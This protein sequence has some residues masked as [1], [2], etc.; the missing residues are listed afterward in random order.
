MPASIPQPPTPVRSDP[1]YAPERIWQAR[2]RFFEHGLQPTGYVDAS[3]I[4]SWERCLQSGFSARESIAFESVKRSDLQHLLDAEQHWLPTARAELERLANG[5]RQAGYAAMLTDA[6]GS[7][8][9]VAGQLEQ[10][11]D[12]FRWAFRP[13]VD[14]SE[15]AIGT[16]AMGLAIAD[17]KPVRVLGGEHF[18][19][20]NQIFH[21]FAAP[22]FDHQGSLLGTIDIS[23]DKPGLPGGLM[24]LAQD[25]AHRIEA[26]LFAALPAYLRVQLEGLQEARLAFNREGQLIA[27]SRSARA[28]VSLTSHTSHT[29]VC[30]FEDIF[31]DRFD[32]WARQLRRSTSSEF[33]LCLRNGIQLRG[34]RLGDLPPPRTLPTAAPAS[35]QSPWQLPSDAAF[36]AE[37]EKAVRAFKAHIPILIRGETGAGKELA[38]RTIHHLGTEN[39][40]PFVAINCGNFAPELI[41]SEL[42]GH[43]D[44]AFTGAAR[45]GHIGKIEAANGGTVLLDEVGDMPLPVQV[46]LLRVLDNGEVIPVGGVQPK[47]VRVRFVCATHKNLLQMVQQGSFRQDLYFRLCGFQLRVP[48]LRERHDFAQVVDGV[49]QQLQLPP[50]LLSATARSYLADLPWPGNVRQL[51]HTISLAAALQTVPGPL[52]VTDFIEQSSDADAPP[53]PNA[54][55]VPAQHA[56]QHAPIS[57]LSIGQSSISQTR[58]QAITQALV[59]HHG[60]VEAAAR[61]LGISRATLY[62]KLKRNPQLIH[63]ALC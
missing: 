33:A 13:G 44:G 15:R 3:L 31:D 21:C 47:H 52:Q 62:R 32:H 7:V 36:R 54:P 1:S 30:R 16:S 20:D 50:S 6:R 5:I 45:G 23:S 49:C 58:D 51:R 34:Q 19:A 39:G 14:V 57:S 12:A 29:D 22:I 24:L 25:C 27:A 8:L 42:F 61:A 63:H 40:A 35:T 17:Q 10:H 56:E 41:A 46:A 38:A 4:A 55:R 53:V 26:R 37:L 28:L 59:Q 18:F 2:E 60:K 48:A 11:S 43:V 9:A